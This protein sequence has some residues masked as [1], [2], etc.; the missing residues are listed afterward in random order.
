MRSFGMA[1]LAASA[2][3]GVV[4]GILAIGP[5]TAGVSALNPPTFPRVH[6]A[7]GLSASQLAQLAGGSK[8]EAAAIAQCILRGECSLGRVERGEL[9]RAD[10][11][12]H[13][14]Q[15]SKVHTHQQDA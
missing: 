14:D 1:V 6:S 10:R 5:A 13:H 4:A 7:A 2:V 3:V 9:V 11:A 12:H 8:S 15:A